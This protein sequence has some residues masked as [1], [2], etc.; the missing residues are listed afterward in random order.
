MAQVTAP[1]VRARKG[2]EPLVMIY[3]VALPQ[4]YGYL[5]PNCGSVA[6]AE[7][8]TAETLIAAVRNALVEDPS[9]NL[10]ELFEPLAG[11]H[12]RTPERTR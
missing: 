2:G 4:V 11:Y 8:L 3:P 6:V 12:E 7:D 10:V 9:G 5:L 1:S